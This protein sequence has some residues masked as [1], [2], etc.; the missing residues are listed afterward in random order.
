MF[1]EEGADETLLQWAA[2][3]VSK[4]V[5]HGRVTAS[6]L[7]GWLRQW[8]SLL[9]LDG[10]DEVTEPTVRKSTIERIVELVNEAEAENLDILVVV[11]TR[12]MGYTAN[13]TGRR[14]TLIV[15]VF[16]SGDKGLAREDERGS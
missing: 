3:Q 10:L 13:S 15:E 7:N 1:A 12:P 6:Q 11:T 5:D 9:V 8:P 2:A 14:N 4:R 16:S